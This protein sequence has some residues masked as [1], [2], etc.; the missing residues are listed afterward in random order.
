[1]YGVPLK[2]VRQ[3]VESLQLD[4]R[5][6]QSGS[7]RVGGGVRAHHLNGELYFLVPKGNDIAPVS[8]HGVLLRRMRESVS[9]NGV[10]NGNRAFP[11]VEAE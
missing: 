2:R 6:R 1:M 10:G 11:T 4:H 3:N 9:G 7:L 5:H 8:I